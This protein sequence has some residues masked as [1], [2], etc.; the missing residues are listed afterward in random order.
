MKFVLHR[1]NRH[2][3]MMHGAS[4]TGELRHPALLLGPVEPAERRRPLRR[5]PHVALLSSAFA[6]CVPSRIYTDLDDIFDRAHKVLSSSSPESS[7]ISLLRCAAS[8]ADSNAASGKDAAIRALRDELAEVR[9]ELA[10]SR[11]VAD[12]AA[13]E[14][15]STIA[16]AQAEIASLTAKAADAAAAAKLEAEELRRL[17][18]EA[19]AKLEQQAAMGRR[20]REEG[21]RMRAR[22]A[23]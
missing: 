15:R 7:R 13:S 20:L 19:E 4:W 8:E 22:S 6:R 9:A 23:G 18:R 2:V 5:N 17:L 12:A 11:S 1:A 16:A 14:A 3:R 21:G 10:E